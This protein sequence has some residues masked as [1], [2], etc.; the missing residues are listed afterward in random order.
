MSTGPT[1]ETRPGLT[2]GT[3]PTHMLP[4]PSF[5]ERLDEA[6]WW[7]FIIIAVIVVMAAQVILNPNYNRAFAA[8]IP[9]LRITLTTTVMGFIF[10]MI[11]GLLSGL[12]R[13]SQNPIVR[14]I[15]TTYIEFIRGVPILVLI[16]TV[17]FVIV[18]PVVELFGINNRS[19]SF[20]I[21][22]IIALA[23]IYG[24]FLAEVFRAGIESIPHGQ[25]EAARSLGMTHFQAMRHIILPQAIRNVLPALGN[26]FIAMLKD[27]SLVSVLGVRDLTQQA[28]LHASSTFRYDATYLVL[29]VV[30]LSMTIILSLVLQWYQ[31]RLRSDA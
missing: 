4:A 7:L 8:I 6:P 15:A 21:R 22:A 29:T 11:L 5:R 19:V 31:R 28:R 23:S 10:A 16:F 13:I 3:D 9:G 17:A 2:L 24:A 26:D 25:M 27:S 12:G 1:E 30:Y 20:E 18:P 14:T